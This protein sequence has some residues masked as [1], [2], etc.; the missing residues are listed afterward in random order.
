MSDDRR[1]HHV[2][3]IGG[4][5]STDPCLTTR[6]CASRLGVSTE[7]I[8]GEIR[9]GRLKALVI[10]RPPNR[11]IFRVSERELAE[12]VRRYQWTTVPD[13]IDRNDRR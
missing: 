4:R 11:L 5:R 7:F 1:S 6:D 12:Y 13:A 8:R 3:M 10:E 2:E 9:D